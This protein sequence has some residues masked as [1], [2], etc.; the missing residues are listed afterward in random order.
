MKI[1][2]FSEVLVL[3]VGTTPQ[4]ITETIQGLLELSP[5][6]RP[7][8]MYIVTTATGKQTV[9][10]RLIENG[11]YS[12]FTRDFTLSNLSLKDENF[13]VAKNSAGS[14]LPDIVDAEES[15][16]MGDL[17]MSLIRE[18]AQDPAAR[19]H[20]SIA[21]GRKTMSFYMGAALQLF[22]RPWDKLYHVL[23]S[24]EFESNPLFFYKPKKN[25]VITSKL[26][27]G[28]V[29]KLQTKDARIHLAELP[30]IR[31][32]DKLNLQGKSFAD[33]IQEGQKKLDTATIQPELVIDLAARTV[34]I[35]SRLIE[36]IP[37]QLMVYAALLKQ[38]ANGCKHEEKPYCGDCTDCFLTL[39]DLLAPAAIEQMAKDY[40]KMYRESPYRADEL[41]T[42][43]Q[44][45]PGTETIRQNISKISRT[46]KEQLPEEKETRP[47]LEGITTN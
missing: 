38:K 39:Q 24:P 25:T 44:D 37:V 32:G 19:L 18:L 31:L 10:D 30:F 1:K 4:I 5:P 15:E 42:K 6:V 27:D 40:K 2:P 20:C 13:V 3:A 46:I 45:R 47:H 14:E 29:K 16:A 21:G 33:L 36:M 23:V 22:G 9:K 35:G 12:K 41:K 11:I 17:I 7:E 28:S 8:K 34:Y 26:P 43:W